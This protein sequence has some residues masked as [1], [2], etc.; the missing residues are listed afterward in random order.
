MIRT[1]ISVKSASDSVVFS[2]EVTDP[3]LQIHV[4]AVRP[5]LLTPDEW[6]AIVTRVYRSLK[7]REETST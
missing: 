6:Y 2:T 1:S 3:E 7:S 4:L 5:G